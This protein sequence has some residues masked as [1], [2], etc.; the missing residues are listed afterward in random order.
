[1]HILILLIPVVILLLLMGPG[2]VFVSD[3]L[4]LYPSGRNLLRAI[5]LG[6]LGALLFGIGAFLPGLILIAFAV[7]FAYDFAKGNQNEESVKH[8][9]E[10]R[11]NEGSD[12]ISMDDV[13]MNCEASEYA[14]V[15]AILRKFR[16]D[17]IIPQSVRIID[18][19]VSGMRTQI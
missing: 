17:E 14:T 11:L 1:M 4:N 12:E 3:R 9:V 8:F 2:V 7:W 5:V 18:D 6:A 10:T 16:D 19:R 13:L 15:S